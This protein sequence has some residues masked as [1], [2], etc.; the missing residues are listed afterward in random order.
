MKYIKSALKHIKKLFILISI[1]SFIVTLVFVA[2]KGKL[3]TL[4]ID[5][6]SKKIWSFSPTVA[7]LLDNQNLKLE[8]QD[9]VFPRLDTPIYDAKEIT[10]EYYRNISLN[11]DGKI[12]TL[13]TYQ[14]TVGAALAEAKLPNLKNPKYSI[15]LET[16]LPRGKS[17]LWISS[18]KEITLY[19]SGKVE[20]LK[21]NAFDIQDFIKERNIVL[22]DGWKTLPKE[23]E[24]LN[25][26]MNIFIGNIKE[27]TEDKEEAIPNEEIEVKDANLLQ[28]IKRVETKGKPGKKLVS[29]QIISLDGKE[30]FRS[31]L[32]SKVL[33]EPVTGKTIVGT[34][35]PG[36]APGAGRLDL[37]RIEIWEAI[38]ECESNGRWNINTG[39]GYYGGLQFS[40]STWISSGGGVYAPTAN[41]ASK[42]QQITIANK[43]AD[44]RGFQ[45]WPHCGS[46]FR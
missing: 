35:N 18:E 39:N 6:E 29:Y 42:E 5:G 21:T 46:R 28:G 32:N 17:E 23:N 24:K 2:Q 4:N 13:T 3:I 31:E 40:A 26:K 37:R 15:P 7:V 33:S 10:V 20:K 1:V 19:F 43:L 44:R 34:K 30:V 9:R 22:V 27:N 38:A 12:S 8:S 14:N 25:E 41:L 45:P 36:S 16:K 11:I